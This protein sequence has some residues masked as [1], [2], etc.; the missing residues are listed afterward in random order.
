MERSTGENKT[1]DGR[2]K[3]VTSRK[4]LSVDMIRVIYVREISTEKGY[5]FYVKA[6]KNGS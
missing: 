3:G 4:T 6:E 5:D 1:K 2:E